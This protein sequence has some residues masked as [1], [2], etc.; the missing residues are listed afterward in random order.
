[1]SDNYSIEIQDQDVVIRFSRDLVDTNA[2]TRF[3][4]FLDLEIIRR[5]SKLTANQARELADEVDQAV[6]GALKARAIQG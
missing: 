6:W 4:D 3:L 1:M 5:R 2:L